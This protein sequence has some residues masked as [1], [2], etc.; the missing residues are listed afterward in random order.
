[1]LGYVMDKYY[2]DSIVKMNKQ[3]WINLER[4]SETKRLDSFLPSAMPKVGD[5]VKV[6][7]SRDT[8][9]DLAYSYT[10]DGKQYVELTYTPLS[11]ASINAFYDK[12]TFWDAFLLNRDIKRVLKQR[13]IKPTWNKANN[14][15]MF[16]RDPFYPYKTR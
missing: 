8:G 6:F 3:E 14:L 10:L 1:M 13:E 16:L 11:N 5:V 4:R 2:V 7:R 9:L 15:R 12:C